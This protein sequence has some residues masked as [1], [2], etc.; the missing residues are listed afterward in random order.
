MI[1]R[2]ITHTESISFMLLFMNGLAPMIDRFTIPR[3]FGQPKKE[4]GARKNE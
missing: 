4:R 2:L 3:S 1:T